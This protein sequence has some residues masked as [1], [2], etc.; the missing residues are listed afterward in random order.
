MSDVRKLRI[1]VGASVDSSVPSVLRSVTQ[2][3]KQAAR[4]AAEAAKKAAKEQAAASRT[5]RD[6]IKRNIQDQIGAQK[7]LDAWQKKAAKD[8][9]AADRAASAATKAADKQAIDSAKRRASEIKKLEDDVARTVRRNIAE[10]RSLERQAMAEVERDLR[11]HN[12]ERRREEGGGGRGGG[13]GG[14]GRI[15]RRGFG[16]RIVTSLAMRASAAALSL[17]GRVLGGVLRGVGVDT[18]PFSHLTGA[19][20]RQK[21]ATDISNSAWMPS[22]GGPAGSDKKVAASTI[23]QEA[24]KT[25]ASTGMDTNDLLEGMQL[26]VKH[27]GDLQTIRD[28]MADLAKLSKANGAE[29]KDMAQAASEVSN[30]LGDVPN[31]AQAIQSVMRALAGQGQ[32]TAIEM[33][34]QAKNLAMFASQAKFFKIDPLHQQ[35]LS[36]AGVT[37]ETSQRIAVV[38]A[39]AQFARSKGG[40]T[41]AKMAMQSAMAFI[42]DTTNPAQLKRWQA[43]GLQAYADPGHT[44]ARDPAQILLEAFKKGR[45]HGGVS[46]DVINNLFTNKRSRAVADA[47]AQEYNES[48]SKATGTEQE[49]HAKAAEAVAAAYER[50]LGATQTN[51]QVERAFGDAMKTADAKVKIFHA[52]IAKSADEI[53]LKLIPALSN[54]APMFVKLADKIA[55]WT[56]TKAEEQGK[57]NFSVQARAMHAAGTPGWAMSKGG[58]VSKADEDE[59]YAAKAALEDELA[60]TE[61]NLR[62]DANDKYGFVG[63]KYSDMSD[64][65]IRAQSEKTLFGDEKG[66]RV[67]Q[68]RAQVK[69]MKDTLDRL[70]TSI[71]TFEV[72]KQF[73]QITVDQPMPVEIVTD[74]TDRPGVIPNKSGQAPV[75]A[76]TSHE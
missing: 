69:E 22:G 11:R 75:D 33:R 45:T 1:E 52:Q 31:K 25:A 20:E 44:I 8:K 50:L 21:L 2:M 56:G 58:K 7:T 65:E 67:I 34:D 27:T 4:E 73:G 57:T 24:V 17:P 62:K 42:Q 29:F 23:Q 13:G 3:Q 76:D 6:E 30:E 46:R 41:T 28:M 38:G 55:E 60:K 35:T 14:G 68:E 53:L 61:G 9:A 15:G 39:L 5:A 48:F 36:K 74:R 43:A 64:E 10:K 63:K 49:R 71:D 72:R 26:F 32:M 16:D 66:E 54:L 37:D 40:R 18:D 47:F 19:V 70:K 59:M 12:S 51:E